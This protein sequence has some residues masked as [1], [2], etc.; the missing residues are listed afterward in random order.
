MVNMWP[1]WGLCD[2]CRRLT[3]VEVPVDP[4]TAG[5]GNN[6]CPLGKLAECE[7]GHVCGAALCGAAPA[8][9]TV[10]NRVFHWAETQPPRAQYSG[11]PLTLRTSVDFQPDK[12]NL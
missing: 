8:Y 3:R 1:L 6:M 10:V 7:C 11:L 5:V 9:I 4:C 2:A 12:P